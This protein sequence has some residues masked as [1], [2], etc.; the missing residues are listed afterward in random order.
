MALLNYPSIQDFKMIIK[1]NALKNNPVLLKDIDIIEKIH[2]K[3]ILSIKGKTTRKKTE[4]PEVT[5][6]PVPENIL[7]IHKNVI[8]C[9]DIMYINGLTFL[10]TISENICFHTV[11][12]LE[13]RE[14]KTIFL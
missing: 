12:H 14:A 7:N 9:A 13:N 3:D 1:T 5:Y 8:L 10:T 4:S 2:R 11:H 6:I